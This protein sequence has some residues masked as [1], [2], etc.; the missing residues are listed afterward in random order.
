MVCYGASVFVKDMHRI[1]EF[2]LDGTFRRSFGDEL[3][4]PYGLV[5]NRYGHLITIDIGS[6]KKPYLCIFDGS[7]ALLHERPLQALTDPTLIADLGVTD[8][9]SRC[10]FLGVYEDHVFAVDLG[11]NQVF[12]CD[13]DG[14]HVSNFGAKGRR[15]GEFEDAAGIAFDGFG[16]FIIADSKNSRL[17]AFDAR[18][19]LLGIV[20]CTDIPTRPSAIYISGDGALYVCSIWGKC[21][22]KYVF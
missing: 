7:G 4:E 12:V 18:R 17:Q 1:Q 14:G 8:R 16:N 3:N 5:V 20:K 13:F 21:V 2:N 11:L 15:V 22:K 6:R 9:Q 10:R 19:N